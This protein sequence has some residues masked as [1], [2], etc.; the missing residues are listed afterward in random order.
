MANPSQR[1]RLRRALINN[2]GGLCCRIPKY[3]WHPGIER[4][5]ARIHTLKADGYD[6]VSEACDL[7]HSTHV[8]YHVKYIMLSDRRTR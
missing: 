8:G 4:V 6:I 1:E 5:A 7:T 2:P 3:G